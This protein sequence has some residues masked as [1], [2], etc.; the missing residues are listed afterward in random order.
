MDPYVEWLND[1]IGI[2]RVSMSCTPQFPLFLPSEIWMRICAELSLKDQVTMSRTSKSAY[3]SP[4]CICCE[5]LPCKSEVSSHLDLLADLRE[6]YL[7][8][9]WQNYEE[10]YYYEDLDDRLEDNEINWEAE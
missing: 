2:E 3:W 10:D 5:S 8:S 7:E 9:L 4:I 6:A 1:F